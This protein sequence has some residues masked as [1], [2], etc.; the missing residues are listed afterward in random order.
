MSTEF[1]SFLPPPGDALANYNRIL[2]FSDQ[3]PEVP[4]I[5]KE[6]MSIREEVFVDE[7]HVPL[8]DEFDA[9]DA[10]SCHWVVYA[11]VSNSQRGESGE[12]RKSSETA[13]MPVGTVRLVPP[14]HPPHPE[15][16]TTHAID[17]AEAKEPKINGEQRKTSMHDGEEP[18]VK[19]GR[20]ATLKPYR[21]LGLGRL[22]LNAAVNWA[23][24]NP[25]AILPLPSPT[26][27][28]AAKV[29]GSISSSDE[30][31]N[32]LILVHAQ[33]GLEKMYA[34]NGFSKDE[35]MGVWV[36]EGIKHVGMWKRVELKT[37]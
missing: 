30:T 24:S 28:E 32:G 15:P 8:V 2:S 11:S 16:G 10:R 18:Y 26:T 13:R 25:H 20:L 29:D 21:G 37:S 14:P 4:S 12:G 35:D 36:E 17:N 31:W 7:Q 3:P 34:K 19:L 27:L 22:L 9:D 6:A 5:F 23:G 1:I 33:E